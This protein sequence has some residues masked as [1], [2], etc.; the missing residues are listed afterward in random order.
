M[1]RDGEFKYKVCGLD[2]VIE[3]KGSAFIALRK[4]AWGCG[5]D[6]EPDP[7]Q[8][9]L[10]IRKY[11]SS[12]EGEKMNKGVWFLSEEGGRELAHVLLEEGYGDTEHCIRILK[13]R[14]NFKD[15]ATFI[16]DDDVLDED[17]NL[18]PRKLFLE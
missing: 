7:S 18:D 2:R 1:H 3:E 13:E 15:A 16:Y 4:I 5:E 11:Y 10:D 14:E 12:G 8:I 9:K 6:E 17:N